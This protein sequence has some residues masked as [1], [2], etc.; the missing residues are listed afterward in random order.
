M[1]NIKRHLS[2]RMEAIADMVTDGL[3]VA[4]VG[5]DHGFID[6]YLLLSGK[7]PKAVLMDI[8]KG[9]LMRADDNIRRF[10]LTEKTRLILSD[11]LKNYTKGDA[12]SLIISGMGGS[13]IKDILGYDLS[14]SR[15]FKE[16]ILSP[17]SEIGDVRIFLN[18]N[19]FRIAEEDML[20]DEGKYYVII[21]AVP[22]DNS[23]EVMST[24]EALYGPILIHE[25]SPVLREY[26]TKKKDKFTKILCKL[27]PETSKVRIAEL[28]KE[29]EI[30]DR[31]LALM[32]RA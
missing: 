27:D 24:E 1:E 29:N 17:Q 23:S 16:L 30:I 6:I 4:D 32:G 3:P 31:T 13:L 12:D 2:K 21:K 8:N 7:C 15:S 11:G 9:P 26:L 5:C 25:N 28:E 20:I 10:S 22:D 18:E 19:G 14:L